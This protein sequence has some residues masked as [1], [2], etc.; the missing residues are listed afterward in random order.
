MHLRRGRRRRDRRARPARPGRRPGPGGAGTS[1]RSIHFV[2]LSARHRGPPGARGRVRADAPAR[3]GDRAPAQPGQPGRRRRASLWPSA[4]R[5]AWWPAGGRPSCSSVGGYAGVA[6]GSGC[7]VAAGAAGRGRVE[8]RAGRGQPRWPAGSR[9]PPPWPSPGHALPRAVVTGNPVRPEVLAV[10][11]VVGGSAR[12]P[13]PSSG[14]RPGRSR[15]RRVRRLARGLRHQ[16]GR[17]RP[18]QALGRPAGRAIYHVVGRGTGPSCRA[19]PRRSS[20]TGLSTGRCEYEDRMP[21]L[22]CG[23]RPRCLP[24]GGHHG[25]RARRRWVCPPCS[26][27][28][29]APRDDHQTANARL[30][31]GGR[32]RRESCP[33][34]SAQRSGWRPSSTPC[35]PIPTGWRR[36]A[37]ERGR[38][39]GPGRPT[40]WPAS[41]RS[42]PARDTAGPEAGPEAGRT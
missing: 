38:W 20:S 10:D 37:A 27:P 6:G 30:A 25:G 18:G 17:A 21:T 11:R 23:R 36:W 16:R 14:C 8:R 9:R 31:G 29:P 40:R 26:C 35:W 34:A 24:G 4:G 3:P 19:G 13:G 32:R 2:G 15:R 41:S 39:D 33:T 22:L 1:R 7:G 42:T 12:R 5:S 28:C